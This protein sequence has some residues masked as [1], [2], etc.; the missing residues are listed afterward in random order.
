MQQFLLQVNT[1]SKW[2]KIE[3]RYV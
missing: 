2:K 3:I 1:L